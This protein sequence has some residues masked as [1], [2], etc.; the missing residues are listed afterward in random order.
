MKKDI[1]IIASAFLIFFSCKNIAS[2][3]N[4]IKGEGS[5]EKIS[6]DVN[7]F[8]GISVAESA[9]VSIRQGSEFKVLVEAQKNIADILETVVENGVLHIRFKSGV[10]NVNYNH[11][12]VYV[13]APNFD[14]LEISGSGNMEAESDLNGQKLDCIISGSG[15]IHL[16]NMNY[17]SLSASLTGSGNIESSGTGTIQN[18]DLVISGSGDISLKNIKARDVKA[19]VTGSGDIYCTAETSLEA[20]ITGSGDIAYDGT[21]SVKSSVTGSG[22]VTK[23]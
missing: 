12:H 8:T 20:S 14:K 16:K 21:P 18:T 11:L 5:V 22:S 10:H 19:Q 6:R 13:Q 23:K 4:T 3:F 15:D 9:D 7:G 2:N 1:L 17:Q